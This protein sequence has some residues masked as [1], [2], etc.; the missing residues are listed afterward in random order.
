MSFRRLQDAALASRDIDADQ[1]VLV[2]RGAA[3]HAAPLQPSSGPAA[4]RG[5][6]RSRSS[7]CTTPSLA[8]RLF[9]VIW[10]MLVCALVGA[11]LWDGLFPDRTD[12]QVWACC[13]C[14]AGPWPARADHGRARRRRG[15]AARHRDSCRPSAY[16]AGRRR[17]SVGRPVA[18]HLR[19]PDGRVGA[20]GPVRVLACCSRCAARWSAS[21][22]AR[23]QRALP[24]R[25]SSSRSCCWSN[26]SCSCPG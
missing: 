22:A 8:D 23:R 11:L 3:G 25:C 1:F 15:V 9:F 4:I 18:G 6:A 26:R 17:A 14:G 13:R 24:W 12:Q 10:P 20:A 16:G 2:G 21:S 5:C 7:S 19:R